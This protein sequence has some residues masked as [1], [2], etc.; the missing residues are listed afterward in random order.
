MSILD[1]AL[2]Y[3]GRGWHIFPVPPDTK[4]S[5]KSKANS[6]GRNWGA[7]TNAQEIARDFGKW[8][9][10]G[11]GIV[12]GQ[13][14]GIF[15]LEIDTVE[16]HGRNGYASLQKLQRDHGRLPKTLMAKSPTNSLHHY[17]K[18]PK[19]IQI[20]NSDSEL[21]VGIDVRGDGGMVIAPPTVRK[22][23]IYKWCNQHTIAN[24]PNWL[25]QLCKKDV[26]PE[27]NPFTQAQVYPPTEIS[28]VALAVSVIP[29]NDVSWE[30]FN[31]MGM[32]IWAACKG[33]EEGFDIFQG[34]SARS[35]KHNADSTREKWDKFKSSPPVK[36]TVGSLFKW[37]DESLPGWRTQAALSVNDFVAYLPD[38]D[39]TFMPTR[40]QWPASSVDS[41]LPPMPKV[42]QHGRRLNDA[43]GKPA[44]VAAHVWIDKNA[45][46][47]QMT[48]CPGEKPL[49]KD[50]LVIEGGW[51]HRN[52]MT[53][54]NLYRPPTIK[55]G[56]AKKAT[57]WLNLVK[58]LY[59]DDWK[60]IV[61]FC[62]QR[63]QQPMIKINHGLVLAGNP[64][65]GKDTILEPLRYAVGPW[66][67]VDIAPSDMM[68]R[69]NSHVKSVVL[70][71]SEARDLGET[72]RY[73][74]YEHSKIL[75]AAPP[76]VLRCDEKNIR[77]YT[78][79]NITGVIIT[80][81]HLTDG[82]YLPED[83]RRH[84]V[85]WSKVEKEAFSSNFWKNLWAWYDHEGFSHVTAFLREYDLSQFNAKTPPPKTEAFWTIVNSHRAPEEAEIS[86]VLEAIGN[87]VACT[88][89]M[90]I[91]AT[92]ND[93]GGLFDWLSDRKNRRIVGFR[94]E[95]C[96]YRALRNDTSKQGLWNVNRQQVIIYAKISV[97]VREQIV[98]AREI[99]RK[100]LEPLK[101][102][103]LV[104]RDEA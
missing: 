28:D 68:A 6:G 27:K 94:L 83:D 51:L 14:S 60:H 101:K 75:L 15:V 21:G 95:K 54:L 93:T 25:I 19:N 63:T 74:F 35:S 62:A 16:G 24:A 72:N 44:F 10:A 96:G 37:A 11:I 90:L 2:Q 31:K 66:N 4:K 58:Q 55:P 70:R 33:S 87:P 81:N 86:S 77:A 45:P 92:R 64:G 46:V 18:I 67:F 23:G 43:K 3:A 98:A 76:N 85:A 104:P 41:Q 97:D 5:Y 17:F 69:F 1:K 100:S 102:L 99:V 9:N 42:D 71:I 48:W 22:D 29:N 59:P 82:I 13:P 52:G 88:L 91:D 47:Q 80:T 49:V 7:T 89:N 53:T 65:I 12:T 56:D 40:E 61:G 84:Y 50:K 32:L 79:F 34:W 26:A 78:I 39:Y 38:H 73:S 103:A 8:P 36:L 30:N 57:P 20:K